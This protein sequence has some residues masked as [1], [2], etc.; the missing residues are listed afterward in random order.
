MKNY[1]D[2]TKKL[3]ID[4][5]S[6]DGKMSA[7]D[8]MGLFQQAVT[9]HTFELGLDFK[10]LKEKY[11][12]KWFISSARLEINERPRIDSEVTVRTWPLKNSAVKFPRAFVMS[13]GSG[14]VLATA[15]TDWCIVNYDTDELLRANTVSFPFGEF[16]EE[17]PQSQKCRIPNVEVPEKCYS[18]KMLVS[19]IDLNR[20]VNNVSYIRI[21]MDC[22][23]SEEL[24]NMQI[25]AMDIQY[26]L[27]CFEGDTL[28]MYKLKTETGYIIEGKR[29]TDTIFK[30]MI[31]I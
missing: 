3:N 13:E 8:I 16:L 5:V 27:Q 6:F 20:H 26:K 15:M 9:E 21:G 19:D 2:F 14:K 11:N 12:A 31:T 23:S 25:K 28:D 10:S 18:R 4:D 7:Y 22:F 17:N 29:D 30:M 24:E 1:L